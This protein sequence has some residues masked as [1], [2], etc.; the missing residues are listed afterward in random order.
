MLIT[1]MTSIAHLMISITPMMMMIWIWV[2]KER[3]ST[4]P[5]FSRCICCSHLRSSFLIRKFTNFFLD[6]VAERPAPMSK[7]RGVQM[8]ECVLEQSSSVETGK[9]IM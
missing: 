3:R 2:L 8:D 9:E 5:T 4:N 6:R 7:R 1:V